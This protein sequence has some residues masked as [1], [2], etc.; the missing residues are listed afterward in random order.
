MIVINV[1]I[2]FETKVE[3]EDARD[4]ICEQVEKLQ[5]DILVM[6]SHGYGTIKRYVYTYPFCAWYC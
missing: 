4:I 5:A 2:C 6:G 3:T 1:Q